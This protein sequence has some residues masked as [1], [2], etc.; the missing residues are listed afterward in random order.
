[1]AD[2]SKIKLPDGTTY[3]VKDSVSGYTSNTGTVTKVSTGAGLTGG[4]ITTS[5]TVK[6][7][8]KSETKSTLTAA[9]K[10]STSSREYAVGL[11]KNGDLSVNV[12]WKD[13][14]ISSNS[15]IE[16]TC[17][18]SDTT[19]TWEGTL[20]NDYLPLTGG[21][22]TGDLTIEKANPVYITKKTNFTVDT[23]ANNGLSSDTTS[24]TNHSDSTGYYFSRF[25]G[26]A[27]SD[28]RVASLIDAR[29]MKTDGTRVSNYLSV[30]V[31]KDGTRYFAMPNDADGDARAAF[32]DAIKIQDT[33]TTSLSN[34]TATS[35]ATATDVTLNSRTLDAGVWIIIYK[36]TFG[37]NATGY[38]RAYWANSDTSTTAQYQS[39]LT[40]PAVNS[41]SVDTEI[42]M[43]NVVNLSS[44]TTLYLRCR[45]NS[46]STLSCTGAI[47]CVRLN[48]I[49]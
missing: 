7:D 25:R 20:V 44:S 14:L 5:G 26:S 48:P 35:V 4:D 18:L 36:V 47:R 10:G 45:Q 30:G 43:T 42:T 32:R 6:C 39:R 37:A 9:S 31:N 16:F 19:N 49:S 12:P 27:Y 34:G 8:L 11:D 13:T 40:Q 22:L 29:N 41:S 33:P 23:S 17:T 21:S 38:R 1:M 24:M 2:I 15:D 46:G 28:G 3:N